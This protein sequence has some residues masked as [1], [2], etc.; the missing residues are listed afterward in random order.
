LWAFF[1]G[2]NNTKK[3]VALEHLNQQGLLKEDPANKYSTNNSIKSY[4]ARTNV[5]INITP[6][7]FG[8]IALFG[9]ILNGNEPDPGVA[10][11]FS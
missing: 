7:P 6:K 2:N 9:R 3:F 11:I 10:S 5:G 1:S 8:S 4:M